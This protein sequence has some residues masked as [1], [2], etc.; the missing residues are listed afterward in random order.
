MLYDFPA[1]W[2]SQHLREHQISMSNDSQASIVEEPHA[3]EAAS[4]V[5]LPYFHRKLRA[6]GEPN[7]DTVQDSDLLSIPRSL[8]IL[9]EPGMGKSEMISYL[10]RKSGVAL[11]SAS[12]FMNSLKPIAPADSGKPLLIDALDEA[13]AR[14]DG[15]AVNKV[16]A[17]LEDAG[18][19]RFILS[20]RAREWQSRAERDLK[21]IYG[22]AP[23]I[24]SIE[25]LT[26]AEAH[27]FWTMRRFVSDADSVLDRM[28]AQNLSDFYKNPLMLTLLGDVADSGRD[29]PMTRA[30]LFGR[31]CELSWPES[32]RSRQD[33]ALARLTKDRAL[34]AAGAMMASA[35]LAGADSINLM[36]AGA[37]PDGDLAIAEVEGLPG[38]AAARVV[39]SSKLFKSTGLGRAVPI[40]RVIAEFLGARWLAEQAATSRARRRLLAQFQGGGPVPA[41]LRGLHAWLAF[42]SPAL[43]ASV[44]SA[45]PFGLLRYGESSAL[46]AAQAT[47]LF[48]ALQALSRDDP[49]FRAQDWNARA[50][51][52]LAHP[53]LESR[54]DAALDDPECGFHLRSLILESLKGE[55]IAERL[56]PTLERVV[57]A[58]NRSYAERQTAAEAL[59]SLRDHRYWR[60]IISKLLEEG[61]KDSVRLAKW[62]AGEIKYDMPDD[63]LANCLLADLGLF[64]PSAAK[65]EDRRPLR[66]YQ[67]GSLVAALSST[68]AKAVLGLLVL[69]ASRASRQAMDICHHFSE[70]TSLLLLRALQGG[71]IRPKEAPALWRWLEAASDH[72]G[73]GNKHHTVLGVEMR[74]HDELRRAVQRYVIWHVKRK[75]GLRYAEH[76]L[77]RRSISI[78]EDPR[79]VAFFLREISNRPLVSRRLRRDWQDLVDLGIRA[80]ENNKLIVGAALAMPQL[81][82]KQKAHLHMIQRPRK[83][84]WQVENELSA[85]KRAGELAAQ[86][87]ELNCSYESTLAETRRG[88]LQGTVQAARVYLGLEMWDADV[89]AKPP[90]ERLS[91]FFNDQLAKEFMGGFEA[92]LHRS[93]L[94][95]LGELATS[96]ATG[97]IFN[98][99]YPLIAGLLVRV[100][101]GTGFGN[102]S[103]HAL[104]AG[105]LLCMQRRHAFV[106]EELEAL[107]LELERAV[108]PTVDGKKD[109]AR[110]WI[111]PLLS[112]CY[113][114]EHDIRYLAHRLGW[115]EA[116]NS[117][118]SEWLSRFS[119]VPLATETELIAMLAS[120]GNIGQILGAARDRDKGIYETDEQA[121]VWLAIDVVYR[122]EEVRGNLAGIGAE[123]S[124]FIWALRDRMQ[125][126]RR[127]TILDISRAAAKW[128][129]SEFRRIYPF[130]RL[131]G[132]SAG[133]TNGYDATEFLRT[134]ISRLANDTGDEAASLIR[135]LAD[136]P[137]DNYTDEIL[138]MMA[139]QR[140]KRAEENFKPIE[141]RELGS[142][143]ANGPPTN[144]DDLKSLIIEELDEAQLKLL[145]DELDQVRDFWSD[146]DIPY[147]EN[148]CRDRLAA[149]ID[150]RLA[151][152][153]SVKRMTE[154]DMPNDKRADLAFAAGTIM[155]L[156]VEVK[157]QWHDDVWDAASS[158]LDAKYLIDWRSE[159]RGVY[160][161]FW[162]GELRAVTGRRLKSHPDGL[163]A[164]ASATEMRSAIINRI[165]LARRPFID[166]IVIDLITGRK[167][168]V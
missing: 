137:I 33:S 98:Y 127:G 144:I 118:A 18:C 106:D 71:Q 17:R 135:E 22:E 97:S 24:V 112:A 157:G 7:L 162:F 27:A 131:E 42:H 80:G 68:R 110:T 57:L 66:L 38:A 142:I 73:Y 5:A 31:V 125:S 115:S 164:P 168:K 89:R 39:I 121:L 138:H 19:P 130:A 129:V 153:Y 156:P 161:V 96:Y 56:S 9:G 85:D 74:A 11:V 167:K 58:A 54:I 63:L 45:D 93:D 122:F 16:L 119:S 123:N 61:S 133:T 108:A 82:I 124:E 26:R 94:P 107:R 3:Y 148:R 35:I 79:D 69:A 126:H 102:V 37:V 13:M 145:G 78:S 114:A 151:D 29:L 72:E 141:P 140:Q 128:I 10:A 152:T 104:N 6:L 91:E 150:T 75:K 146:H 159:G 147:G 15:D 20:C 81:S 43:A 83:Y 113:A 76:H 158:Q 111:E 139:E 28:D 155:Q 132:V 46:D 25:E 100:R 99:S 44:I 21:E 86:R 77:R 165:P 149:L 23:L 14:S 117:L 116:G 105:L 34:S 55:P 52:S 50:T 134:L 88:D 30:E 32:D 109:V 1:G 103:R 51:R 4:G 64:D 47:A 48:N 40:H 143:L 136:E 12:R 166:V 84:R 163:P 95:S 70:L 92:V 41:S 8:V 90:E 154:A 2:R 53:A 87:H 60:A 36:G 49:Y 59:H 120:T 65:F 62:L 101:T 67:F 160:C